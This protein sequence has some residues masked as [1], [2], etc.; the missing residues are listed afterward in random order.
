MKEIENK[1]TWNLNCIIKNGLHRSPTKITLVH[2]EYEINHVLI[3]IH[4]GKIKEKNKTCFL[5]L[6]DESL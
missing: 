4:Q 2:N 1:I 6:V 5:E 3:R